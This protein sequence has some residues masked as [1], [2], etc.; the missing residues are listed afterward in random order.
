MFDFSW[1]EVMLIGGVALVVIGP[2]DLPKALRTVGQMTA[3]VKRMAAEF[4]TQFNEAMR[5]ADLED[6]RREVAD[7]N[8]TVSSTVSGGFNPIQTI[9]DE[10]KSAVEKPAAVPTSAA[11]A[12]A[13]AQLEAERREEPASIE[14]ALVVPALHAPDAAE[15]ALGGPPAPDPALPPDVPELA[16]PAEHPPQPAPQ[17]VEPSVPHDAAARPVGAHP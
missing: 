9:R 4:H 13:T 16:P 6:A 11:L 14:P 15:P 5:E 8:R 2:K 17:T 10:I 7:L 12:E 1:G 3:K